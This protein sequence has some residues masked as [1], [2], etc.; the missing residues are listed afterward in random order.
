MMRQEAQAGDG[1]APQASRWAL[2]T[3]GS[4]LY[5][6]GSVGCDGLIVRCGCGEPHGLTDQRSA[7][8]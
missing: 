4:A 7:E 1:P 3:L 5:V 8:L 2:Q 6:S